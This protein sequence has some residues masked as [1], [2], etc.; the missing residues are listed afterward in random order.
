MCIRDSSICIYYEI[1]LGAQ[2]SKEGQEEGRRG[3]LSSSLITLQVIDLGGAVVSPYCTY[4]SVPSGTT[5]PY[6]RAQAHAQDNVTVVLCCIVMNKVVYRKHS[7]CTVVLF[8][9]IDTW[10]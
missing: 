9:R 4:D 3:Q 7:S 2:E 10:Y 8:T 1:M 6:A 5:F